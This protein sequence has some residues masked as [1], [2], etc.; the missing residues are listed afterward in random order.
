MVTPKLA[1]AK[2]QHLN[3]DD[4]SEIYSYIEQVEQGKPETGK[5][6]MSSSSAIKSDAAPTQHRGRPEERDAWAYLWLGR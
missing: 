5:S 4:L 3:A 1:Q 6:L 2:L